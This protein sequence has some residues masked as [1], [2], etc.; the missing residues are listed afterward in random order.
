[1]RND[2]VVDKHMRSNPHVKNINGK[3]F[4]KSAATDFKDGLAMD[5]SLGGNIFSKGMSFW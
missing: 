3:A 4:E 2:L 5:K 1:M